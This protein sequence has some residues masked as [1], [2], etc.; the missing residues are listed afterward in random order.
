MGFFTQDQIA[1]INRIAAKS[2]E[3]ASPAKKNMG[4]VS[5]I[6]DQLNAM[7]ANVLKYFEGSEAILITSKE[8]LHDYIT[9]AIES[10][11]A[12]IDTET[13]GL[14]RIHDTIVGASLY[15][16]GGVECYI[17]M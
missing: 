3:L 13:T 14:D 17:P 7:S 15:Y 12:G 9:K 4:K 6:N 10:G 5:S 1:D 2:K 8:E 16:P 11:Y